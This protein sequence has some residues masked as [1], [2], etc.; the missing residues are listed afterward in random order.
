MICN[1]LAKNTWYGNKGRL[2]TVTWSTWE[3]KECW[4]HGGRHRT[5][6]MYYMTQCNSLPQINSFIFIKLKL[7]R[8]Q[9]HFW[10]YT[11]HIVIHGDWF[12]LYMLKMLHVKKQRQRESRSYR[13]K[14]VLK[15]IK[16]ERWT[17]KRALNTDKWKAYLGM[18]HMCTN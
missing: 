16:L 9:V 11:K 12:S 4:M 18:F 7:N 3:F 1:K 15:Y 10:R 5:P 8:K 14:C 17:R 13:F 6:V 2:S